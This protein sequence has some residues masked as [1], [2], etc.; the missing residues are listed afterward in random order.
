MIHSKSSLQTNKQFQKCNKFR[1]QIPILSVHLT[2][3]RQIETDV[4]KTIITVLRHELFIF[5]HCTVGILM[6]R[7]ML[8]FDSRY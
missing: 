4:S 7:V 6:C 8:T 3:L 5:F 1:Q 2:Q